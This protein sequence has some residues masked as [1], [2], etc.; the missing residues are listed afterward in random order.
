M[1]GEVEAYLDMHPFREWDQDRWDENLAIIDTRFHQEDVFFTPLVGNTLVMPE[2]VDWDGTWRVNN[3]VVQSH[4][5]HN[6]IGRYQRMMG[7]LYVDMRYRKVQARDRWG[8]KTQLDRRDQMVTRFGGDT[9]TF[10]SRVLQAMLAD[11][12]VAQ[13]ERVSRDGMLELL[14]HRFLYNGDKFV[15][16]TADFSDI[17]ADSSGLFEVKL[18]ED[19][20][21]RMAYRSK[22]TLRQWGNYAQPVPGKN[23]R[24]SVLIMMTTGVYWGIWNADENGYMVDLRSLQD[25]RV[26]NGGQV[27]YRQF[28]TISDTMAAQVLWNAGNIT[29]QVAVTRPINWGDGATDP[30]SAAVDS[31]FYMGQSGANVKHYLQCSD[32]GT[33]QFEDGDFVTVHTARTDSWGITDGCDFLDGRSFLAEVYDVDESNERLVLRRCLRLYVSGRDRMRTGAGLRLRD[34][35]TAHPPDVHRRGTRAP[36]VR[37]SAPAGWI[38]DRVQSPG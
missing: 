30:D 5:N 21:L 6:T 1:A 13:Q 33:S 3:E 36:T 32:L 34:K 9:P 11:N 7:P 25:E 17:P 8:A 28:A 19:T 15:A 10:I 2:G 4:A 22:F 35:G 27:Q 20:A 24:G 38:S 18:L 29:K 37:A 23:F 26:I 16:G 12:I 31:V 14:P